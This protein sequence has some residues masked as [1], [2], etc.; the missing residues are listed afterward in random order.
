MN[1]LMVAK[2]NALRKYYRIKRLVFYFIFISFLAI[3]NYATCSFIWFQY[4]A[5]G[6]GLV[7]IFLEVGSSPMWQSLKRRM[8][9]NELNKLRS[10]KNER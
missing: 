7:M 5:L 3:I 9:D 4:P 10:K 8:V 1:D 2:R 6:L